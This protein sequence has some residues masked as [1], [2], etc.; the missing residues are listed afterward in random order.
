VQLSVLIIRGTFQIRY[1]GSLPGNNQCA[2]ELQGAGLRVLLRRGLLDL[3][4]VAKADPG[5]AWTVPEQFADES[6]LGCRIFVKLC[7]H[8]VHQ[9]VVGKERKVRMF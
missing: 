9:V 1:T 7:A 4:F 2:S 3:C 6:G 8:A 5:L